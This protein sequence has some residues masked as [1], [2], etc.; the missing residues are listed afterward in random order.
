MDGKQEYQQC[1]SHPEIARMAHWMQQLDGSVRDLREEMA[2]RRI[3]STEMSKDLVKLSEA[4]ERL[5]AQ[6]GMEKSS[7]SV[8]T[9]LSLLEFKVW[10]MGALAGGIAGII[11]PILFFLI[12]LGLGIDIQSIPGV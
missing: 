8:G 1:H 3:A 10:A 11:A 6:L 2:E 7:R 4:V 12:L 9:R 5:T